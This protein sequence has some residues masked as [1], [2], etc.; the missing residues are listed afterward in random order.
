MTSH[1]GPHARTHVIQ[2]RIRLQGETGCY[3]ELMATGR[4]ADIYALV[5]GAIVAQ[6][7][8]QHGLT[9]GELATQLG[10]AQP[11]ISR[12]ERGQ[13][14]PDPFELRRLGEV[15]GMSTAELVEVIDR[16]HSHAERAARDTVKVPPRGGE[17]WRIALAAIGAVG[18][19]GL[20]GF[21]AAA[22]LA[23]LDPEQQKLRKRPRNG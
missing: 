12:I 9:Q 4:E 3:P 8:N 19:A 14:R 22:A 16:A 6:L 7:R 13:A 2:I 23:K 21:A 17:W 11:T 5:V 1:L 20:A 15:F 10:V 18:L